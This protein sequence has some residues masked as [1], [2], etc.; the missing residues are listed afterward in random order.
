MCPQGDLTSLSARGPVVRT[1]RGEGRRRGRGAVIL[2][3]D[4]MAGAGGLSLADAGVAQ[5]IPPAGVLFCSGFEG[6]DPASA[7]SQS[8]RPP[9]AAAGAGEVPVPAE[10]EAEISRPQCFTLHEASQLARRDGHLLQAR[11]T[12]RACSQSACPAAIR[13]DCV[14][15][16]DQIDR[17]LPS[18]VITARARGVDEANVRV[19]L[20]DRLVVDRLTGSALELDPGPHRF[21][22]ESPPWPAMERTILVGAGVKNRALDVEFAPEANRAEKQPPEPTQPAH[23]S[24]PGGAQ[25]PLGVIPGG[26]EP[27]LPASGRLGGADYLL[28]AGAA[29]G[30]GAFVYFGATALRD[31]QR[32]QDQC[33]PFCTTSQVDH[34]RTS[35]MVADVGLGLATLSV[36]AALYLH[37]LRPVLRAGVGQASPAT[38]PATAGFSLLVTPGASGGDVVVRGVF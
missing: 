8:P 36:A 6:A 27:A 26:S 35:L 34:V 5:A 12:L 2:L 16:L 28:G 10:G 15:W 20:D 4:L 14:D 17:S 9:T 7:P 23:P 13:A 29:I 18:V 3:F 37:L 21:R 31:R 25:Q 22:F 32:L 24:S 11:T 38:A 30:L 33:A 1:R 19:W